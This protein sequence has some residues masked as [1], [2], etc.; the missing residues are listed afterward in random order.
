MQ[1][2]TDSKYYDALMRLPIVALTAFFLWRELSALQAYLDSRVGAGLDALAL[3]A[4]AAH[5]ATGMF[6]L[7]LVCFHVSR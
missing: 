2:L 4:I 1:R 7:L 6:L 3:A 5:V